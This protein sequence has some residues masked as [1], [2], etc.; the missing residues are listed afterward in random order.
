LG[1]LLAKAL[2]EDV[3]RWD[4]GP[5]KDGFDG[6]LKEEEDV[7]EFDVAVAL[8]GGIENEFPMGKTEKHSKR[9]GTPIIVQKVM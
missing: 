4:G 3:V 1:R 2:V 9:R 7:N 6:E 8:L 5:T